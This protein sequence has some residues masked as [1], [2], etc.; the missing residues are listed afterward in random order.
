MVE[1]DIRSIKSAIVE[2]NAT[3]KISYSDGDKVREVSI[4]EAFNML[5]D[6]ES[7]LA[8]AHAEVIN[9]ISATVLKDTAQEDIDDL[10][11]DIVPPRDEYQN[12]LAKIWSLKQGITRVNNTVITVS[13]CSEYLVDLLK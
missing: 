8:K 9:N 7:D 4:F 1:D 10:F 3:S 11:E 13:V 6:A 12:L 5:K 2:H